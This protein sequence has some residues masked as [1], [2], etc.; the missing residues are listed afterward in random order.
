[1]ERVDPEIVTLKTAPDAK[2]PH[3]PSGKMAK[4]C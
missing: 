1:M 2:I 3:G 4:H